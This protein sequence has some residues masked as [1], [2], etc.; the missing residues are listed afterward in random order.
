MRTLE[1]RQLQNH[2]RTLIE[3]DAAADSPVVSYFLDRED[4]DGPR[5]L[6]GQIMGARK[7]LDRYLPPP[8]D[9]A[10]SGS[11]SACPRSWTGR[12]GRSPS[13]PAPVAV[14]CFS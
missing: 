9:R 12:R 2:L 6:R 4:P 7:A 1:I 14:R 13:S 11:R 5:V 3:L 8:F 10:M